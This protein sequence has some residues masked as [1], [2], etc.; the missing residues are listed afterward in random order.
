MLA[1]ALTAFHS[2]LRADA[3]KTFYPDRVEELKEKDAALIRGFIQKPKQRRWL[4]LLRSE[5]GRK[6]LRSTLAHCDDF[7]PTVIVPIPSSQQ[8]PS[9]IYRLLVELGAS[10]TCSLISENADLDGL[11][12]DLDLALTRIVGLGFGTIVNC[13]PGKL[14][15][16]EGEGPKAR[17]ILK[18]G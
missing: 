6:K 5:K 17:F 1:F 2:I 8:H 11:D 18:R 15:F 7:D 10:T 3:R 9:S 4:E 14:A 12:L 13:V 16:F